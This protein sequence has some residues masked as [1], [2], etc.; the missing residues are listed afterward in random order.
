ML[1]KRHQKSGRTAIDRS[2]SLIHCQLCH[3]QRR[4]NPNS[5]YRIH[6]FHRFRFHRNTGNHT[7]CDHFGLYTLI[8]T[9][10]DGNINSRWTKRRNQPYYRFDLRVRERQRQ[11][12]WGQT[13][14]PRPED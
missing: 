7:N 6:G 13:A 14:E 10:I 2:V 8:W 12:R 1:S 3:H 11:R 9:S 4:Y 5:H